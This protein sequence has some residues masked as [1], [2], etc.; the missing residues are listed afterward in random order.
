M[1]GG[2]SVQGRYKIK[3]HDSRTGE[4]KRETGWI[5]NL[6]MNNGNNGIRLLVQHLLNN[7]TN[8]IEIDSASI[9]TSNQAPS[10]SDTDLIAPVTTGVAV[11]K[12]AN[13]GATAQFDFFITDAQLPDGTYREFGIFCGPNIFARSLIDP[14]FTKVSNEDVTITYEI[15]FSVV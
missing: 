7:K 5:K 4:F 15:P 10:A 3:V 8:Q 12:S 14:E 1:T 13:L 9:G 2:V 11:A 6:V